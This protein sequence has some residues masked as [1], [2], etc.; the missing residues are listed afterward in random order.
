[1]FK[2]IV[3]SILIICN[4]YGGTTAFNNDFQGA[5]I[6]AGFGKAPEQNK[7]VLLGQKEP[8]IKEQTTIKPETIETEATYSSYEGTEDSKER[9]LEKKE[10]C[11]KD[12][13]GNENCPSNAMQCNEEIEKSSGISTKHEKSIIVNKSKINGEY[14][15]LE[16]YIDIN[17]LDSEKGK[18]KK[19]YSYYTYS[20]ENE[21]NKLGINWK[22]VLISTGSDCKGE[23]GPFGCVCNDK[24][25]PKENCFRENYLCPFDKEKSCTKMKTD[26]T[27]E[28]SYKGKVFTEG[29]SYLITEYK[30]KPSMNNNCP[31]D[32]VFDGSSCK[33]EYSYYSYSCPT[34]YKAKIKT[35]NC[36]GECGPNG[37][38]CGY[39]I[40][41]NNC[42]KDYKLENE[43]ISYS[44][45]DNIKYNLP[46]GEFN[47][48]WKEEYFGF[49]AS[50]NNIDNIKEIKGEENK[51]CFKSETTESCIEVKECSFKGEIKKG[52]ISYLNINKNN[53]EFK[54]EVIETNCN[55]NGF[56]G[57][58]KRISGITTVYSEKNS[59][60]FYDAFKDK[61]I[62]FIE[63]LPI[64]E[65]ENKFNLIGKELLELNNIFNYTEIENKM[66]FISKDIIEK[67]KCEELSKKYNM[68]KI[69]PFITTGVIEK[70][71]NNEKKC[72]LKGE[73]KKLKLEKKEIVSKGNNIYKCSPLSCSDG[74]CQ[75]A[76]CPEGYD[77]YIHTN[78]EVINYAMCQLQVCDA[79]KE[80]SP[81]CGLSTEC[82][83][84]KPDVLL[85]N[86]KC[87]KAT[88]ITGTYNK[89]KD[90]CIETK[91]PADY[92]IEK[93]ICLKNNISF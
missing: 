76:S 25:P 71:V 38:I 49:S 51:L 62:G 86:D 52:I 78:R 7:Q 23:C 81:Y 46:Q 47:G 54:G 83:I 10:F 19:E 88:C 42:E 45:E 2:K 57:W 67:N 14:K 53:L 63:F 64:E 79:N 18:C 60:L 24:N 3:A 56:V 55:L 12:E 33:K 22:G 4:V 75:K 5:G 91:C 40:E 21:E 30:Y 68:K 36:F 58:N 35:S 39:E 74:K 41:K 37:C 69:D 77:G 6:N 50:E 1:M 87:Q 90:K 43:S 8:P 9:I 11:L 15:C 70:Y 48:Q 20:C 82:D 13:N 84:T 92:H 73:V 29:E 66:W 16:G 72:I 59:L 34:G 31:K 85:K 93:D 80:Y 65:N 27:V 61:K 89:E 28:N 32:Y 44:Y 17:G 26:D